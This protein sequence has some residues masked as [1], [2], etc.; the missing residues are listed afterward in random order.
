MGVES[1]VALSISDKALGDGPIRDELATLRQHGFTHVHFSQ[2][3][4]SADPLNDEVIAEWQEALAASKMTVLDVHGCHPSQVNLWSD[5]PEKRQRALALFEHRLEL[6]HALGGDAVVYHVPTRVPA[7]PDIIERYVDGLARL[8]DKARQLGIKVALEN[9]YLPENDRF[10][11]AACFERF[12]P[13]YIGLTF[14]S[15]HA[16]RSG[17]TDWLIEY[18]FDRL[19]VLHLHDNEPGYDRHWLPGHA[20]GHVN[21]TQVVRAIAASPYRKPLQLETGWNRE[22]YPD[23]AAFV[24]AAYEA[25]RTLH[26]RITQERGCHP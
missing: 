26:E 16:V 18:C 12:S 23:H 1:V 19:T 4:R 9:H 21:W 15:G 7:G 2:G 25:A 6:T 10:V 5:D 22:M 11:L 17:N 24:R 3:W 20:E 13:D 14:D 8:E